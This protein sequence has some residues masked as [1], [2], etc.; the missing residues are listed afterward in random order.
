MCFLFLC[1]EVVYGL[2]VNLAKSELVP[3]RSMGN[4]EGLALVLGCRVSPLPMK[5]LSLLLEMVL[6][7]K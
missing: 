6:L 5:Y 7:R 4:V 2:K 3:D 1:F